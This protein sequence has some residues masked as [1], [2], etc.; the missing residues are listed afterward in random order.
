MTET[1]Q[2]LYSKEFAISLTFLFDSSIDHRCIKLI[3]KLL[4]FSEKNFFEKLLKLQLN[5]ILTKFL[6]TERKLNKKNK[7]NFSV[8][9]N[10]SIIQPY[11]FQT[12]GEISFIH[13]IEWKKG[14]ICSSIKR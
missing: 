6:N 8:I 7:R 4:Q 1:T 12:Q 13:R 5:F 3:K 10:D 2:V 11:A 14:T 9:G